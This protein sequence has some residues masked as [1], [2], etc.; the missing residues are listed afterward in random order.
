M[1]GPKFSE[2]YSW[3]PLIRKLYNHTLYDIN[4]GIDIV[5]KPRFV[6]G[7]PSAPQGNDL[8]TWGIWTCHS[9]NIGSPSTIRRT[10]RSPSGT[11]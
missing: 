10:A 6:F 1:W 2:T 11:G 9:S 3:M 5:A 7:D 4:N 8:A